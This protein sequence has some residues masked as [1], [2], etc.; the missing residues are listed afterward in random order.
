MRPESAA[1]A[2]AVRHVLAGK[3]GVRKAA[4]IFGL[5]RTTVQRA[6]KKRRAERCVESDIPSAE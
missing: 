4:K 3:S 6:L 2:G 1:T 5:A